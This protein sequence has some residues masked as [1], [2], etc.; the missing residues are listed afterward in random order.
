MDVY[1]KDD[2]SRIYDIEMQVRDT[3]ELP[4]RSRYYQSAID[5]EQIDKGEVYSM[6]GDSYI[7][8][9][10]MTDIFKRGFHKY[11]F[12]NMC[13]EDKTLLLNDGTVKIFLNARGVLNDVSDELK[14]F[15]DY[16]AGKK[17]ENAY[18]KALDNA[19]ERVKQNREWRQEYMRVSVRD[20]DNR[21]LGREE[22]IG[23][24]REEGREAGKSDERRARILKMLSKGYSVEEIA[25]LY[26]IT[27]EEVEKI[28]MD[29]K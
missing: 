19:V 29:N 20:W 2:A 14:A 21:Q 1:V 25:D 9:I 17:S 28:G 6:L 4:Q 12:V 27:T 11:T 7:I 22:G 5:V 8:F 26:E 23:I 15:L 18:I 10:C 16:L 13:T 24:G 3:G